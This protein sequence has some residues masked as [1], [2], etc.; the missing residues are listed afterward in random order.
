[1]QNNRKCDSWGWSEKYQL[2]SNK[3]TESRKLNNL[4]GTAD[5]CNNYYINVGLEMESAIPKSNGGCHDDNNI[6]HSIYL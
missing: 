1:M 3:K 6:V 4:N 5:F 2:S